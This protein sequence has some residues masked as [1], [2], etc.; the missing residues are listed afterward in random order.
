ML[1]ATFIFNRVKTFLVGVRGNILKKNSPI[2]GGTLVV[3]M[4]AVGP[5]TSKQMETKRNTKLLFRL[6]NNSL[7][8]N[9]P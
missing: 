2:F 1:V 8:F 3:K 4:V 6:Q 7:D 9:P 5:R